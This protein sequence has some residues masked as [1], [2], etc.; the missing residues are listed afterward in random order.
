MPTG[1]PMRQVGGILL[2][3]GATYHVDE[4]AWR[5]VAFK[6]F[7]AP[8]S[9]Q[10]AAPTIA[11]DLDDLTRVPE[12]RHAYECAR[13]L[14]CRTGGLDTPAFVPFVQAPPCAHD[15]QWWC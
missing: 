2:A 11:V 7:T 12:N 14:G 10:S 6:P 13:R 1:N 9:S 3:L 5:A 8:N 15:Q 4:M